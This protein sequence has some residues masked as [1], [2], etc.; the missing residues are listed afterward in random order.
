M[1]SA[2]SHWWNR[3]GGGTTSVDPQQAASFLEFPEFHHRGGP[4]QASF[5]EPTEFHHRSGTQQASFLEP[6]IF[7]HSGGPQQASFLEPTEFQHRGGPQQAGF[8]EPTEFQ[9]RGGTQQTSFLEPTEFQHRGGPQQ[10]SFLEPPMFRHSPE[11]NH[12]NADNY[13]EGHSDRS[14]DDEH[15]QPLDWG[16]YNQLSRTTDPDEFGGE[17]KLH[18]D[19]V[20]K[21]SEP[22]NM[23]L[24][25][26]KYE[27]SWMEQY[28]KALE[29]KQLSQKVLKNWGRSSDLLRA[30]IDAANMHI[31]LALVSQDKF[32]DAKRCLEI[33][34]G[35]VVKKE[36]SKPLE[37]SEA[38]METSMQYE[39][40]NEFETAISLLKR[41]QALLEKLPQE[42]HSEGSVSARIGWLLLLTG[43]VTQA[44]P[45]LESAA[46]T[47]KES[48]GTKHF[49]VGYIYNNLGAAYLELERHQSAAQMFAVAK[50]I[51]D[52][53]LGPHHV[54]SIEACQNLSKAYAAM[55][56]YALAIE[57]QQKAVDAWSGHGEN[58][59]N[60][61][62]EAC[63]IL[64]QLKVKA[65]GGSSKLFPIKA[66][67]LPHNS[68]PTRGLQP[69]HSPNTRTRQ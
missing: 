3:R 10:T 21:P 25:H 2:K 66:L 24:D 61:L 18:F 34:S 13:C 9:H 69:S 22:P 51:M 23:N 45:Y 8:L 53:S 30:E 11:F 56:S 33:A 62:R 15:E 65:L 4:H 5:L 37:A 42:Q 6:P 48:F 31:A 60:E 32:A 19:D 26:D 7:R 38:Y 54:D 36:K 1:P 68:N 47:L 64:D 63:G 55:E 12:H 29:Q 52:V 41:A 50:D 40:M 44:I 57:F 46:E 35:I 27:V 16:N 59:E 28:E 58:A 49:G 14:I 39:T 17:F 20:Y 43:K 67:P